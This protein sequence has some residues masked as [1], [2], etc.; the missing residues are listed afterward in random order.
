MEL[1]F[2][3]RKITFSEEL[4]FAH[5]SGK[6]FV[7]NKEIVALLEQIK[8]KDDITYK[9]SLNVSNLMYNFCIY[10]EKSKEYAVEMR[11][12]GLVHDCGKIMIPDEILKKPTK[13]TEE[14]F[15]I[16]KKHTVY[17]ANLLINCDSSIIR[18]VVYGHHLSFKGNGY[19]DATLSGKAIPEECRIASV[20]DVF[21][22]LTAK[23]QYKEPMTEKRALEIMEKG[24]L[25]PYILNKF[26]QFILN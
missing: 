23:R 21:E 9:H 16:M 22:A 15:S 18:N 26:K 10:L 8:L 5:K 25:D 13:L 4:Y 14:E 6:D 3:E 24:N 12:A 17:G 7:M 11:L 19:P 2:H 1:R 20:C